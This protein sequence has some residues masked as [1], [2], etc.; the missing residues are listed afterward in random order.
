[1]SLASLPNE[2]LSIIFKECL[3]SGGFE[4]LALSCRRC[5]TVGRGYAGRYKKQMALWRRDDIKEFASSSQLSTM[6]LIRAILENPDRARWVQCL[7]LYFTQ[8]ADVKITCLNRTD[9]EFLTSYIT[10]RPWFSTIPNKDAFSIWIQKHGIENGEY[11]RPYNRNGRYAIFKRGQR[12]V[13]RTVLL[14]LLMYN[15]EAIILPATWRYAA[16]EDFSILSKV[17][18]HLYTQRLG[19]TSTKGKLLP[20]SN[21]RSVYYNGNV[22][23]SELSS[24]MVIT[25][26]LSSELLRTLVAKCL[27]ALDDSSHNLSFTWPYQGF[28]SKLKTIKLEQCCIE[29]KCLTQLLSHAPH[30]E[31]FVYSHQGIDCH[32]PYP[33]KPI[34]Y[35]GRWWSAGAFINA[36]GKYAGKTLRHL[37][38][39]VDDPTCII[40]TGAHS[41]KDFTA[42]EECRL[43][44]DTIC[45]PPLDGMFTVDLNKIGAGSKRWTLFRMR[46]VMP[47][48]EDILPTSIKKLTLKVNDDCRASAEHHAALGTLFR[49]KQ[50][51]A[52]IG[53]FPNLEE[54]VVERPK[55]LRGF[56]SIRRLLETCGVTIKLL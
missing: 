13:A 23:G 15:A 29:P 14:L 53:A 9:L 7:D 42:L 31:S 2:L 3:L 41:L 43:T 22:V 55:A 8:D 45:A 44:L 50:K 39:T 19:A 16:A 56:G 28:T 36:I 27:I 4:D 25:P 12:I 1:M 37:S 54:I 11:E 46:K 5:Y 40:L 34:D 26:F 17:A 32:G 6:G 20:L 38:V 18:L 52:T 48:I 24:V 51:I 49:A 33:H 35:H 47:Q 30:V 10:S 21:L